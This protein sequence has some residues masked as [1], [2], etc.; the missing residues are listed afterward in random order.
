MFV[1]GLKAT[2]L[3]RLS[4]R[5]STAE[6][7]TSSPRMPEPSFWTFALV[8]SHKAVIN[9]VES[10]SQISTE[11]GRARAWLRQAIN[12]GLLVSYLT[13]MI[14]DQVSL[15]VHYERHAFLRDSEMRD[16]GLSFLTGIEVYSFR[17]SVNVSTL[18]RWQPPPL[19]LAGIWKGPITTALDTD[20]EDAAA[21]LA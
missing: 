15:S 5:L 10:Q 9:Q 12:D 6:L 14:A 4:S 17:P 1:H 18:N 20:A 19:S 13:A 7:G 21:S 2:F 11:V 8:F 16:L 3:G